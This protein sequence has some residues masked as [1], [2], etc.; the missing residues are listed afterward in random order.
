M[1]RLALAMAK[2]SRECPRLKRKSSSPP[3]SQLPRTA[4][5]MA[6]AIIKKS[7]SNLPSRMCS[8]ASLSV[9]TP[10]KK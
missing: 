10:P 2:C 7:I 1:A 6:A 4:A 3:S 8:N 9:K 5:P